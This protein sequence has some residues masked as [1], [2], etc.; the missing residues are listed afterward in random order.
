MTIY[1][2]GDRKVWE[3]HRVSF[4]ANFIKVLY[5]FIRGKSLKGHQ[6]DSALTPR[7]LE[8]IERNFVSLYDRHRREIS[9]EFVERLKDNNILLNSFI[10]RLTDK[11]L[12]KIASHSRKKMVETLAIQIQHTASSQSAHAVAHHVSQFASTA[13]GSQIAVVTAT[14]IMKVIMAKIGPIV[15][16]FLASAAFKKVI[17]AIAH[18]LIVGVITST[19]LHFL[20]AHIGAAIGASAMLI[21]II[22]I[23]AAILIEKI[24][25]F[26]QKLG[27]EVSASIRQHLANSFESRNKNILEQVFDRIFWGDE[28]LK[29]VTQDEGVKKAVEKLGYNLI[30][31]N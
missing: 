1:S 24:K 11:V 28:L 23:V 9:D 18:K 4:D 25:N 5:K 29:A 19:V 27:K 6:L 22:P 26:P 14:A 7:I 10:E 17:A 2:D 20:A 31:V 30:Y 13:L 8:I 21:I 16:K 3:T 12:D 15:A